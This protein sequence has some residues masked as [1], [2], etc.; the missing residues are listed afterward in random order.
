MHFRQHLE[1]KDR[2][3][4]LSASQYH[5][6]RYTPEKLLERYAKHMDAALGTRLHNF[7]KE[8]ILLG[9][10]LTNTSQTLNLY[11]NHCIGYRMTPEQPLAYSEFCFGT[12]DAV[13][14][15][16]ETNLLRIFDLKNGETKTS[17]D[18]LYVYAALFC[19]EYKKRPMEIEYDLRIYQYDDV[20]YI[21]VDPEYVGQ[22][23]SIIEESD[24][25]LRDTPVPFAMSRA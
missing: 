9:Q 3:A 7:A 25:L 16:E 18:Q 20:R 1:L 8:A 19:L 11:V 12:A 23:M 24:K 21:E 17:E 13:S 10:E 22:V 15:D 14:F 6:L 4:F 5:W 2:H